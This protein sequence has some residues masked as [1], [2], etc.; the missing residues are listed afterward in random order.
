MPFRKIQAALYIVALTGSSVSANELTWN[1]AG[2]GTSFGDTANWDGTPAGGSIDMNALVDDFVIDDPSACIGCPG[3]VA[4]ISWADTAVGSLTMS[5][6]EIGGA[7]GI[8]YTTLNLSGGTMTRQFLL[9]V[10]ATVSGE[11]TLKLNGGGNPLNLSTIALESVGA[12]VHFLNETTEAVISEHLGKFS[13]FGMPAIEGITYELVSDGASGALLT[14]LE[15]EY[16]PATMTWTGSGDGASFNDLANW[17]GIPSGGSI[18]VNLLLDVYTIGEGSDVGGKGVQQLFFFFKGALVMSGG[19]L[20]QDLTDGLAGVNG[21]Q[22]FMS[23]GVLERQFLRCSAEISGTASV[24]LNGGA[25]PL[26]FGAVVNMTGENCSMTFLNESVEDFMIEHLAKI[27]VDGETAEDGVNL[28]VEPYGETGCVVTAISSSPC[29]GDLNFDGTVNGA[30]V[31]LFLAFWGENGSDADINGDGAVNGADL[32]L[33]IAGWGPCPVDPCEGVDCDDKDPCTI[34]SCN[35]KTGEC[36][37]TP[38]KGCGKGSCGDPKSGSCNEP[39]GTPAC[40]DEAC[41][42]GVCLL[43]SFCCDVEWD[44][45]CVLLADQVPDC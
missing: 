38:I 30:D 29:I 31:G 40:N 39:N 26:P 28:L 45:S 5:G 23:G 44:A 13:F 25:D 42:K 12:T 15:G 10:T 16:M 22:V 34:D 41:C 8:R 1:G 2:D 18:D 21:G 19:T 11:A 35:P 9:E 24:V 36:V 20:R 43:D 4:Q 7:T 17:D 14:A 27:L 32:G 3:G 37:H 33:L 6:G